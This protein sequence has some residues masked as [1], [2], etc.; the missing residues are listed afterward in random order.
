MRYNAFESLENA[1]QMDDTVR[2]IRPF[3]FVLTGFYQ[4]IELS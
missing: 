2:L 4:F 1:I 3:K